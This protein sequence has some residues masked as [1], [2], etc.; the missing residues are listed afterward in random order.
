MATPVA[1]RLPE[2]RVGTDVSV[3]IR[4]GFAVFCGPGLGKECVSPE[5]SRASRRR[6]IPLPIP[7]VVRRVQEILSPEVSV[8]NDLHVEH[9]DRPIPVD[10]GAGDDP[11]IGL[12]PQ[13]HI[14]T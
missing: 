12:R 9:V 8:D 4:K 10:V 2:L 3:A 1:A 6:G 5:A 7:S 14:D 13:E 11:R